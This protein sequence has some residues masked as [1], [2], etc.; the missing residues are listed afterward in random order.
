V[1]N[2][3]ENVYQDVFWDAISALD[4]DDRVRL[5]T[6]AALGAPR[7]GFSTDY[8]LRELLQL[9]DARALPAFLRWATTIDTRSLLPQQATACYVLGMRGCSQYLDGPPRPEQPE[10]DADRAWHACGA[11]IFWLYKPGLSL[12]ERRAAAAQW[13]EL[14]HSKWPLQAVSVL[15]QLEQAG[16]G[17]GRDDR[18]ILDE[19]CSIFADQVRSVLEFGLVNRSSLTEILRRLHFGEAAPA[20]LIRWL[21]V[22][23]N[24]QTVRLLGDLV[25]AP[26]L[27]PHAVGALRNLNRRQVGNP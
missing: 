22:V 18:Q 8:I 16:Y 6:M 11:I 4:R 19:L 5:F 25:D 14:L 17:V 27:G 7:D 15:L 9:A 12:P 1:S 26:D 20:T 21:G 2:L 23:G 3:F 10:T 13:W 24:R